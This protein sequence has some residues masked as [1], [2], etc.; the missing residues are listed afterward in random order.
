MNNN[1]AFTQSKMN[2]IKM[3]KMI[4]AKNFITD[5]VNIHIMN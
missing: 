3:N 1:I 5:K 4:M 2:K